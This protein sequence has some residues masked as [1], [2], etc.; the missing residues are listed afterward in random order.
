[1][2]RVLFFL[3]AGIGVLIFT[4]VV[5]F[6]SPQCETLLGSFDFHDGDIIFIRGRT[7]RS[8]FVAV[9]EMRSDDF[10]HVGIVR[11]VGE[12]PYVIHAAP[13]AETVK[14]ESVDDFLSPAKANHIGLYRLKDESCLAER[15][16]AEAWRWLEKGTP[17]DH[18]FDLSSDARLYCTELVW[19]AYKRAGVDL[20]E[21]ELDFL[22]DIPFHGK[23]I[24]PARLSRSGLL[25]RIN[26]GLL[27]STPMRWVS[28]VET[29]LMGEATMR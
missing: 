8:F 12:T 10:S 4:A 14:L 20:S 28:T 27:I 7:W 3:I 6:Y 2:R 21:A 24:L 1:V 19:L 23:V 18:A 26:D 11:I 25:M 16:A 5:F 9:A 17:F 13:E 29:S 15:A 22:Y